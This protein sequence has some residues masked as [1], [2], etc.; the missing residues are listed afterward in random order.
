MDLKVITDKL[1]SFQ[2]NVNNPWKV[3]KYQKQREKFRNALKIPPNVPIFRS[4]TIPIFEKI[5]NK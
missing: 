3:L 5:V 1:I 4:K 2:K